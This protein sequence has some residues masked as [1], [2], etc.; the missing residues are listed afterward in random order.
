[1]EKQDDDRQ[2]GTQLDHH[3]EHGI[4]FLGHVQGHEFVQKNQV[5]GGRH[6][7]PLRDALHNTEE[8]GF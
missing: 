4:K 2:D 6:R 7:Q 5:T 1:M 3:I 8:H